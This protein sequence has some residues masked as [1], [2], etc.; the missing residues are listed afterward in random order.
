MVTELEIERMLSL[1]AAREFSAALAIAQGSLDRVE[2][3]VQRMIVL[4]EII[5]CS[6]WLGLA[7]Q[8]VAAVQALDPLVGAEVANVYVA[9]TRAAVDVEAGRSNE[10]LELINKNLESSFMHTEDYK[11]WLYDQF[12]L[13][14][15]A[16]TRLARCAEALAVLDEAIAVLPG[17]RYEA[18]ILVCR[19]NCLMATHDY[20]NAFI[21][22]EAATTKGEAELAATGMLQMAECRMWQ[23]RVPEALALY[24]QLE[25]E[26]PRK[27]IDANRVQTGITRAIAFLE[28]RSPQMK[29]F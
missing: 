28:K 27:Y 5:T 22:A 26:L 15:H 13:K 14:A 1:S 12:V 9:M 2:D 29:P 23:R 18:S 3:V 7:E 24:L 25:K 20:E 10:A 11:D 8:T 16:L 6:T 21:A 19:S 17:G 4:Y